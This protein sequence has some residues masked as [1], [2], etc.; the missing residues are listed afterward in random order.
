MDYE[1]SS[2]ESLV[3][4]GALLGGVLK[5]NFVVVILVGRGDGEGEGKVRKRRRKEGQLGAGEGLDKREVV[6][7]TTRVAL[8]H[9]R[10]R[11]PDTHSPGQCT[12]HSA[13]GLGGKT[14][15]RSGAMASSIG[16]PIPA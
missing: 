6:G 16:R 9:E 11:T 14:T 12:G 15:S 2:K 3:V 10:G 5:S 4:V 7:G 8:M 13:C 1:S